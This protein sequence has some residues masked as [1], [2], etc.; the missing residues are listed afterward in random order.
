MCAFK[1]FVH[2]I[3]STTTTTTSIFVYGTLMSPQVLRILLGRVPPCQSP[4]FVT[5]YQ[6]HPVK[7]Q[8]FPGMIPSPSDSKTQG[9]LVR[10]LSPR[11]VCVLDYFEGHE[12]VRRPVTVECAGDIHEVETYVWTNPISEL[13]LDKEWDYPQFCD[14]QL[15]WYLATTVRP[16]RQEMDELGMG[17]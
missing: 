16:C 17:K 9:V 11:E 2:M 5:G 8:V 1:K 15:E 12:Y 13:A 3:P 4:A 14:T 7:E 6:R 10:S